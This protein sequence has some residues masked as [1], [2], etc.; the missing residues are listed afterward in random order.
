M[1][2]TKDFVQSLLP[3]SRLEVID[4]VDG[5]FEGILK[6]KVEWFGNRYTICLEECHRVGSTK[7]LPGPQDF[8]SESIDDIK[9]LSTPEDGLELLTKVVEQTRLVDVNRHHGSENG[10]PS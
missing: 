8:K 7:V 6:K 3:G 5:A 10:S 9:V 2:L 4:E 1:R